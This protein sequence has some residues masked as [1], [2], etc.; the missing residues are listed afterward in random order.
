MI[1]VPVHAGNSNTSK[2]QFN[3]IISNIMKS[4]AITSETHGSENS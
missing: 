3:I 1:N 4:N 2:M